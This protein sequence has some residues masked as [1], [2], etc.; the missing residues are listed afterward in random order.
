MGRPPNVNRKRKQEKK[1]KNK[2]KNNSG[3]RPSGCWLRVVECIVA[4]VVEFESYVHATWFSFFPIPTEI[5]FYAPFAFSAWPTL[6]TVSNDEL[7]IIDWCTSRLLIFKKG[8]TNHVWPGIH[9]QK[10]N[11]KNDSHHYFAA[12]FSSQ[13]NKLVEKKSE[14]E[15]NPVERGTGSNRLLLAENKQLAFFSFIL[16]KKKKRPVWGAEKHEYQKEIETWQL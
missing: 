1:G 7:I 12:N 10:K 13:K 8:K 16:A 6:M 2:K 4:V 5:V 9:L 3:E 11:W 14:G 15:E